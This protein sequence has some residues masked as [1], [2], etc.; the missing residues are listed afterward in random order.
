MSAGRVVCESIAVLR[1]FN[2]DVAAP[3][4]EF[5]AAASEVVRPFAAETALVSLVKVARRRW[6]SQSPKARSEATVSVVRADDA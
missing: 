4:F 6:I 5:S 3:I 2:S 1:V